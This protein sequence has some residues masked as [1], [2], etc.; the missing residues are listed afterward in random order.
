MLAYSRCCLEGDGEAVPRMN[1]YRASTYAQASNTSLPI[2]GV[3]DW[4]TDAGLL[5]RNHGAHEARSD[6]GKLRLANGLKQ[7][8]GLDRNCLE[9]QLLEHGQHVCTSFRPWL[10]PRKCSLLQKQAAPAIWVCCR[11]ARA[12]QESEDRIFAAQSNLADD[13]GTV[14]W[15]LTDEAKVGRETVAEKPG[16]DRSW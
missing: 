15:V 7:V 16:N 14:L 2:D 5:G 4:L 10:S 3:P 12:T 8:C 13:E 1:V 11:A 9:R 6:E